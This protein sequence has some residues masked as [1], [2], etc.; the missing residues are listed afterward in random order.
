MILAVA[1]ISLILL[2]G[3]FISTFVGISLNNDLGYQLKS[4][5]LSGTSSPGNV[6][7]I[8]GI[9]AVILGTILLVVYAVKLSKRKWY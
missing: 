2:Y 5:L 6:W 7:I 9:V 4:L 3:G 8:C 1:V